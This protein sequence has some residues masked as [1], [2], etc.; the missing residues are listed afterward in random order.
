MDNRR[1]EDRRERQGEG[2]RKG[3]PEAKRELRR[4]MIAARQALDPAER[5]RAG[6]LAQRAVLA[7][8]EWARAHTVLLYMPV[9]GEVDTAALA[10]AGRLAGKRLLL[11]RVEQG[12]RLLRLHLW[13]GTAAQ[14][15]PGAYG[16]PEPRPDLPQVAP[17]VVDL[18]I[19]PGVAFDRRGYRLGYGG[20][21]YDR[22]LPEL[23]HAVRIGLGYG[24][25]LVDLLPAEPH[26]VRLDAL[27]TEHGLYRFPAAGERFPG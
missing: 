18:V 17:A 14:L 15:V 16:I 11:P 19:V 22:L 25:Q 7:A 3:N 23:A 12:D 26:D 13:D 4:R 8:P 20:G 9:R 1:Q 2:W 5:A 6:L 24:F 10:E 27:A 21:Y